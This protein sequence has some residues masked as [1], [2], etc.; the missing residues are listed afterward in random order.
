M[1]YGPKQI[2]VQPRPLSVN[3][4]HHALPAFAAEP[5]A[6]AARLPA[7]GLC[8]IFFSP[9]ATGQ[10]DRRTDIVPLHRPRSAYYAGSASLYGLVPSVYAWPQ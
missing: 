7:T 1:L 2:C 4:W 5:R 10:A 8:Q 9:A 3:M 6:T